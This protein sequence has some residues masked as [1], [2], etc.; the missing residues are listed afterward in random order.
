MAEPWFYLNPLPH[1]TAAAGGADAPDAIVELPKEEAR[2]V[3]GARRLRAGDALVLCDGAGGLAHGVLLAGT[4][5]EIRVRVLEVEE[6]ARPTP[7]LH[8]ASALPKGDRLTSLLSMAT[9]LG[10]T[11]FSPLQCTHSVVRTSASTPERWARIAREACKQSRRAH[12]PEFRSARAPRQVAQEAAA[13]GESVLLFDPSG[14]HL[15]QRLLAEECLR[16]ACALHLL[17]GPEGGFS[18]REIEEIR[19]LDGLVCRLSD[20][21]LRCETAC[22][23]VLA[24]FGLLRV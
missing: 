7:A 19:G 17:V 8:L 11:S 4:R 13:A 5:G 15:P 20:G 18:S 23:A 21:V 22:A 16:Q 2:H 24:I 3:A 12:L 10:M 6:V 9:Q 14:P 1:R